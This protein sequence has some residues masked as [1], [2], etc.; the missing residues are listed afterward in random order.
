MDDYGGDIDDAAFAAV[1]DAAERQHRGQASTSAAGA[2]AGG[3]SISAAAGGAAAGT[4]EAPKKIVQPV[5]RKLP[6]PAG[7]GSIIVSIRQVRIDYLL[8]KIFKLIGF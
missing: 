5:P 1:A 6:R 3:N 8:L 2:T 7:S 4:A